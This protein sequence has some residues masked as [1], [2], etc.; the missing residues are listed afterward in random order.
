MVVIKLLFKA[1]VGAAVV[2][3]AMFCFSWLRSTMSIVSRSVIV[4][5]ELILLGIMSARVLL[6]KFSSPRALESAV[7]VFCVLGSMRAFVVGFPLFVFFN[8]NVCNCVI[9]ILNVIV[10]SVQNIIGYCGDVC[11][12]AFF[13]WCYVFRGPAHILHGSVISIAFVADNRCAFA[14]GV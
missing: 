7:C 10:L 4:G 1:C 12:C 6:F 13:N 5:F 2:R 8:Y 9:K 3:V 11:A 14:I